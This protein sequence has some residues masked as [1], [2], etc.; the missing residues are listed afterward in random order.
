VSELKPSGATI[1]PATGFIGP[2]VYEPHGLAID[3]SSNLWVVNQ[4]GTT[5]TVFYGLA[6]PVKTPLIG[7]PKLP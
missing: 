4:G 2:A 7:P 6:A 1:S 5:V 3:L